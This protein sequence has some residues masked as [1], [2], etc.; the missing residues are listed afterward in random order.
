[1]HRGTV[2][3]N[4]VATSHIS[5][6]EY[7]RSMRTNKTLRLYEFRCYETRHERREHLRFSSSSVATSLVY[8]SHK[9]LLY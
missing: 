5:G 8:A 3:E 7:V 9:N 2:A 6:M 4:L 1:M